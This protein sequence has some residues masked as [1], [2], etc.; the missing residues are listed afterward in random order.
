MKTLAAIFWPEVAPML[1]VAVLKQAGNGDE[2]SQTSNSGIA[3]FF[4]DYHG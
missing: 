3:D 4:S 1:E 2:L